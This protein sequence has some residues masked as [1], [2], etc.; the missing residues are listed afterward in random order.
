MKHVLLNLCVILF[1]FFVSRG[2]FKVG[3]DFRRPDTGIQVPDSYVHAPTEIVTS[4]PQ[5]RWWEVFSDPEL[6]R[7]VE[8]SLTNNFDIKKA[9]ARILEVRSQFFQTRADRFPTINL[10]GQAERQSQP[11]IGVLPGESFKTRTDIHTMSLPA[12]FLL[13]S[14]RDRRVIFTLITAILVPNYP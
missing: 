14:W 6:N 7:L 1:A 8:E 12:S 9:T 4:Q 3:P 2:C 5:D 13:R 11:V 10:Q